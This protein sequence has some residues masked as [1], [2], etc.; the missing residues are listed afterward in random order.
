MTILDLFR[1]GLSLKSL[2]KRLSIPKE[3]VREELLRFYTAGELRDV[4]MERKLSRISVKTSK[5]QRDEKLASIVSRREA[6]ETLREIGESYGRSRE[7]VRQWLL[8][9]D[10]RRPRRL[11]RLPKQGPKYLEPRGTCCA[12]WGPVYRPAVGPRNPENPTCSKECAN[13]WNQT[14]YHLSESYRQIARKSSARYTVKN[15]HK[16]PESLV[17]TANKILQG[18]ALEPRERLRAPMEGTKS[19]AA[20]DRLMRLRAKNTA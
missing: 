4:L 6:G 15:A 7:R 13:D 3:A 2:S 11:P 10:Y 19:R 20:W 18:K 1:S 17:R 14:R 12:C 16:Y 5:R 8:G 9:T